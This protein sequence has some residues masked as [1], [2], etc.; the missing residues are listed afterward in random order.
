MLN[1]G[2]LDLALCYAPSD[3]QDLRFKPIG[4]ETLVLTYW[5]DSVTQDVPEEIEFKDLVNY[6]LILPSKTFEYRKLVDGFAD[7][8]GVELNIVHEVESVQPIRYLIREGL[9]FSVGSVGAVKWEVESGHVGTARIVNPTPVRTLYLAENMS[10]PSS[11]A[12]EVV[13][14]QLVALVAEVAHEHPDILSVDGFDLTDDPE[15]LD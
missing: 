6:P 13:R 5:K 3:D 1:D 10:K 7:E 8:I 14:D 12:I 4:T 15:Q 11:R 2:R 9:G